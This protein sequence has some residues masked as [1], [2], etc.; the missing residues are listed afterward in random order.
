MENLD[1]IFEEVTSVNIDRGDLAADIGILNLPRA[2]ERIVESAQRAGKNIFLATQFL[3]NME[4]KPVPLI[5]EVVDLHRTINTGI[6]G[7]QLSEETAIG[8]YPA[9]CVELVFNILNSTP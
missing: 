8:K 7:I 2:Q 6:S 1:K 5:S 3:K 9:E 4:Q